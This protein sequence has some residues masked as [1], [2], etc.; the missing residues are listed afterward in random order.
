MS[1]KSDAQGFDIGSKSAAVIGCGGLGCNVCVH[2]AG[3]GIG[4]LFI[5][6]FDTVCE[7]NLNRQFV[8]SVAD[9][10]REKTAVM[11]KHLSRYAPDCEIT[12]VNKK[13]EKTEDLDF[14]E[15]CDIVILAVD[16]STVRKTVSEFCRKNGIPL[17]NGG[18]NGLY[19][20]CYLY[21]PRETPCLECAGLL[22]DSKSTLNVSSTAGIIGSLS[23]S[24]A[25]RYLNGDRSLAGKLMI[26][27]K[28][29]ITHLTVKP[30]RECKVCSK[31]EG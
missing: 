13:I 17:I 1:L 3:A 2:L 12:A 11:L 16:N 24:L 5:C 23:V 29:E 7:K 10:G 21:I 27:D 9:I 25:Q 15:N 26:Y 18:I 20:V 6:D 30:S 22:N 4:R 31:R 14:A 28:E 8:Y 19:G